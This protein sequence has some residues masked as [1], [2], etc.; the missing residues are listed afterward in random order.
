MNRKFLLPF[1]LFISSMF[2]SQDFYTEMRKNYWEYDEN[3]ERAFIYLNICI[4]KAKKEKDYAELFQSYDD[5]IRFSKNK[6]LLYADSA[7]VAANKSKNK[8]LIGSSYVNKGVIFYF[9][10]RK[11]QPALNEYLKGYTY[12]KN[13]NDPFLKYQN[14]YHIGVMKSY[15]G[16]YDEAIQIF[17]E[18]IAYFEPNTRA[19]IHHNLILNNRKGYFN[20]LHQLIICYQLLGNFKEAEKLTDEGLKKIPED[21]FFYLDKNY[22]EKSKGINQFHQKKYSEAINNLNHSLPG[23][24]KI[25]NFSIASVSYFYKGMSYSEMGN[26]ELAQKNYKKVD[27]IFNKHQFI[28]PELRKN[29]EELI[30]YY[31]EKKDPKQELYFT[32]QLLKADSVIATDFKYLSTR[33]HKNYD[34]E[35]LLEAKNKLENKNSFGKYLLIGCLIIISILTA[36]LFYWLKR[37]KAIKNKYEILLKKINTEKNTEVK[38]EDFLLKNSFSKSLKLDE[39]IAKKILKDISA[40]EKSNGFIEKGITLGKLA[41]QLN[42]NTSY[43]SQI[44]NDYSGANFNTY[45]NKLRVEYATN[46]IYNDKD[47][48]K[49]SVEDIAIAC[50]FSNRQN[51]SNFFFEQ[52]RMRPADFLKKRKE[53]L[54]LQKHAN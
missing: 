20:S 50:G 27:S 49:Y 52:Y 12:L 44:I 39:K 8:D 2:C 24:L 16:Y 10:Y 40:F 19:N 9:N 22:F 23:L 54:E 35:S 47:W 48:R 42:T 29:Y 30:T 51:F 14:L 17:K 26:Q 18:C 37:K 41:T 32:K 25:D 1:F 5:A 45:I 15:L 46:K 3:D 7:I 11:Y 31:K 6:K 36:L 21:D 34:T 43:L 28:L 38:E 33:I 53:E 13:A 4:E